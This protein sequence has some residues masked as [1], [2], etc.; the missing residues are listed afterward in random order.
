MKHVKRLLAGLLVMSVLVGG[1]IFSFGTTV[2]A[3]SLSYP[4]KLHIDVGRANTDVIQIKLANEGD[5]IRNI[6]RSSKNL[7]AYQTSLDVIRDSY[8]PSTSRNSAA[9][10]V[11]AKKKGTYKVTFNIYDK[12]GKKKGGTKSVKIYANN[13]TAVKSFKVDGKNIE[14]LTYYN[15][16][17]AR[18]KVTMN[19]GYKLKKIEVGTYKHIKNGND[20]YAEMTYKKV[21]NGS[22]ITL[23]TK[24]YYWSYKYENTG[25]NGS[26]YNNQWNKDMAA[27]TEIRITYRDKYTKQ[28]ATTTY[29]IDKLL[30]K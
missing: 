13:D 9:I 2:S 30:S 4:K 7:V 28:T 27:S 20:T 26:Y 24:P 3:A 6:K 19:K 17:S 22:K 25:E 10:G 15:K 8:E 5:K 14:N 12:N 16:K 21:R 23:G 1:G 18:I 11:Y 29:V